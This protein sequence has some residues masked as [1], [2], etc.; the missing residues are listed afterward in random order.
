MRL[1]VELTIEE[2]PNCVVVSRVAEA[3]AG[4]LTHYP[5]ENVVELFVQTLVLQTAPYLESGLVTWLYDS[6]SSTG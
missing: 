1:I 2:A 6:L 3:M 5:A 4:E